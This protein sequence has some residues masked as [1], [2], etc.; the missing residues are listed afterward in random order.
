[1][2]VII[3]RGRILLKK[4]SSLPSISGLVTDFDF[5]DPTT[6]QVISGNVSQITDK[7]GAVVSSQGT[8]GNRPT[9]LNDGTIN[10]KSFARFSGSQSLSGALLGAT[11]D[12]TIIVL[13][14][15]ATKITSPRYG[16]GVFNNGTSSNGYG[17]VISQTADTGLNNSGGFYP[18][19]AI[20]YSNNYYTDT[21]WNIGIVS[22]STN[23][24]IYNTAGALMLLSAPTNTLATPTTGHSIGASF[25]GSMNAYNGD[26]SRILVYN[27]QLTDT[28]ARSLCAFFTSAYALSIPSQNIYGGHSKMTGQGGSIGLPNTIKPNLITDNYYF[29]DYLTNQG[30]RTVANVVTNLTSEV[31]NRYRA[32]TKNIYAL[33]IGHNDLAAAIS[34]TTVY[35]SIV[36]LC[37]T[38][39][40]AGFKIIIFTE[41]YTT[42]FANTQ[43]DVMNGL[44]RTNY[45]TFADSICDVNNITNLIDPTNTTYFSDGIHLT[46]AAQNEVA[47]LLKPILEAI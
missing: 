2:R 17:F 18:G 6:V 34:G 27:R 14:R 37:N 43:V 38:V 35:N 9:F 21:R 15:A 45:A 41:T 23:N 7:V 4:T 47:T 8:S 25:F 30:G 46:Q 19:S 20:A 26:I 12:H 33:W 10:N 40:A 5:S 32:S 44:I 36:S 22:H 16:F 13:H 3:N 31:L 39:K 1:M 24:Y 28:E 42:A 29:F 11:G